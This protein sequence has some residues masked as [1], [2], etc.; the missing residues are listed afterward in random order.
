MLD[1]VPAVGRTVQ[2]TQEQ[3]FGLAVFKN[4]SG[5]FTIQGW[6][7]RHADMTGCPNGQIRQYPMRA[8]LAQDPDIA[9]LRQSK[10]VQVGGHTGHLVSGLSPG[11]VFHPAIRE[12][13]GQVNVIGSVL[14]PV[15]QAVQRR[16]LLWVYS[17]GGSLLLL[18]S[19]VWNRFLLLHSY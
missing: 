4:V 16:L 11:N 17:H 1:V 12:R 7:K 9:V 3:Q 14:G 18:S 8:I 5:C 2:L 19:V 13:L 6:V 10:T 15:V